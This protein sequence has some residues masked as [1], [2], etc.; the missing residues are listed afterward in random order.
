MAHH[1][2]IDLMAPAGTEVYAARA[3]MV[4][5]KETMKSLANTS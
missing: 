1:A 5:A 3:G 4:T 2:G